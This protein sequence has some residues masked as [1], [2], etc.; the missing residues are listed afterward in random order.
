MTNTL[1]L[2]L[3]DRTNP[4][5]VIE[6]NS[7]ISIESIIDEY[8]GLVF[9]TCLN[10]LNIKEDAEEVAQDV[11]VDVYKSLSAFRGDSTLKTWIY[12]ICISKSLEF[13]NMSSILESS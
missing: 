10:F 8:Q 4:D 5:K 11:F 12:R 1:D 9:N 13:I 7:T 6:L 3:N 2:V